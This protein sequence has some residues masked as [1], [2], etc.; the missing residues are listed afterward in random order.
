MSHRILLVDDEVDILEF[1]RYNLVREGYE[2]YTAQNGAE[3]LQRAATCRPHLILLDM[4][5]PVMDGVETCR[6]IRRDPRLRD[7]MIVFLSA[8]GE[9]E[10]QLAGF[11]VGADDYLTKPIKMKLLVSRVQAILKRID[12][13]DTPAAPD[14][15]QTGIT[16]DRERHTVLCDG[17]EITLPRKEFALLELLCASVPDDAAR[18]AAE[19]W[20]HTKM[21]YVPRPSGHRRYWPMVFV[22][23]CMGIAAPYDPWYQKV[24][25]SLA[26]ELPPPDLI[27][28]EGGNLT[29]C[30]A[31]SRMFG[32]RRCLA[33][34]H[35]QTGC[36]PVMDDIYGGVLALSEFIR[37][38]YLKTS[39]L[40]PQRAYILHN[41][42]DTSRFCPGPASKALRSQLGFTD[43]DFIV[44]YCGRLDPDKGIHKLMEAIA[45]L[46]IPQIKLL[47]V[48]SPFFARTQQ[49]P[50]QRRLE[51]QAKSLGSRVQFT[52][53]IPNEDLPDYYRLADLCC[54]PTL[55]E[56]AAGLVAVE[57]M[58]CGRPVLATRS[59]GMPEYLQGSQAVLV[60]RGDTVADQLAWSIRMLY[61]HPA[62]CAE[63]GAAGALRGK[64]FST[65]HYYAE[66]VRIAH[67]MIET[68]GAL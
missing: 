28:A 9:E 56:E 58:A 68:G 41:C 18:R 8:L 4:M 65:E 27:V 60:E 47:I 40:D 42:I 51:Q 31:I 30:S 12:A 1:V 14:G 22:E 55:V 43:A 13:D 5:M 34:L 26:L 61:E 35:G 53:Y 21:L 46:P 39:T 49:S 15:A 67:D 52:G 20:Q 59:G 37:E 23:R 54:V 63:M 66:F 57:A 33:H 45:A 6:A 48:G 11:G 2:V 16:V 10:Q 17:R 7:T 38:D 36:T 3:A 64:E 62:L 32:R 50:F 25:L 44:L 24:Q 29:Q 19:G